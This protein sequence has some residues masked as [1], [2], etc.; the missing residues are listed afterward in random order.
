MRA[1]LLFLAILMA[2]LAI[3]NIM[4]QKNPYAM[5]FHVDMDNAIAK[6]LHDTQIDFIDVVEKSGQYQLTLL[7]DPLG[8]GTVSGGGA[9]EAGVETIL[10]AA[11]FAGARFHNWTNQLGQIISYEAN[12]TYTMPPQNTTL[13]AHFFPYNPVAGIIDDF[14]EGVNLWW[15]PEG[16]GSTIG[17]IYEDNEGNSLTY[18]AHETEIVNP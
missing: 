9:F 7:A 13:T 10:T 3:P 4:A 8:V 12:F 16:S 5:T 15:N 1:K 11:N 18:K 14:E 17:I 2:F 6:G